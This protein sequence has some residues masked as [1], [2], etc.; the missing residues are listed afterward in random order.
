MKKSSL[1]IIVLSLLTLNCAK[2]ACDPS[3]RVMTFNV[4]LNTPDDGENAWPNRKDI[5]ASMIR[6]HK[7]DIVG[8]QEA[9][10]DQMDDLALSLPDYGWYGLG[11]DDGKE[12]GEYMSVF[13]RKD[14][15]DVLRDS[16]LWLSE[17]P[18][19]VSKGWDAMCFRT[20]TVMKFKD[21]RT[22]KVFY[23]FNTHFDHKGEIARRESANLLLSSVEKIAGTA[24]VIVT[25]DF[26]S[27]PE[28]EP[29]Q[30][31]RS[32]LPGQVS[33]KL[34][35]TKYISKYPH[36]GPNGTISRFQSANLPDNKTIDY[37]FIKN[38]VSVIRHGTLSDSFDG[39]FPSD[40]LLVL[41]ELIIN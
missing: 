41:A 37:I 34:I 29:Y 8:V 13:Y 39:R 4:R 3:I 12:A 18:D 32:G 33:T 21:L 31:L 2:Q 27:G 35:D 25:G 30:I 9:L 19:S 38:K 23:L 40:H 7:A 1:I 28:S 22:G 11:R 26:N 5:A 15:F 20:V 10:K 16:T 24:P 14:R 17:T 6:F 36:H